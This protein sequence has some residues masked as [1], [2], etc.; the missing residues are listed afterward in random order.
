MA[1]LPWQLWYVILPVRS[2]ICLPFNIL[3]PVCIQKS[4]ITLPPGNSTSTHF[5]KNPTRKKYS[6]VMTI[7]VYLT[8]NFSRKDF[9]CENSQCISRSAVIILNEICI[10]SSFCIPH[11]Y[12]LASIAWKVWKINIY[13]YC[14]YHNIYIYIYWNNWKLYRFYSKWL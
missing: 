4:F 13:S 7:S 9:L 10:I 1:L 5:I 3:I 12:I 6:Q 2:P 8:I 14:F 11:I